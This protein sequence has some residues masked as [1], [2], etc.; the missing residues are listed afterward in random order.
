M[1]LEALVVINGK[2]ESKLSIP[3]LAH[4][5]MLID[6]CWQA[7][8]AVLDAKKAGISVCVCLNFKKKTP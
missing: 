3:E 1:E 4:F 5:S 6:Y 2:E 8:S 7:V